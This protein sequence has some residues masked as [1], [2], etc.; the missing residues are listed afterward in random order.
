MQL[1]VFDIFTNRNMISLMRLI[2]RVYSDFVDK[3]KNDKDLKSDAEKIIDDLFYNNA[4]NLYLSK[5]EA[6]SSISKI[7]LGL[8]SLGIAGALLY[9][10]FK[11]NNSSKDLKK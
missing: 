3:I 7:L 5:K 11:N 6:P 8:G 10:F 9:K 1:N 2:R 4:K